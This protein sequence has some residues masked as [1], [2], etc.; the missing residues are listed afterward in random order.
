M[1]DCYTDYIVTRYEWYPS[2]SP[3]GGDDADDETAEVHAESETNPEAVVEQYVREQ[4]ATELEPEGAEAQ[5]QR[6]Q[7]T[8]L[9]EQC[10]PEPSKPEPGAGAGAGTAAGADAGADA[11][12]A[13]A[14]SGPGSTMVDPP[15]TDVP[16]PDAPEVPSETAP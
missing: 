14:E 15:Q 2:D 4:A 1:A 12:D 13:V 8:A 5:E 3:T 11:A 10:N 9:A 16:Q 6:R 7:F